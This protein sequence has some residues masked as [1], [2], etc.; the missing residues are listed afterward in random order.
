MTIA[1]LSGCGSK[2]VTTLAPSEKYEN[3]IVRRPG[4]SPE[5]SKVY[6]VL[7]HKKC[8]IIHAEWLGRHGY[9]WPDDVRTISAS[10]LEQIPIGEPI[11]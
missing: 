9:K 11:N 5:D 8:W 3:Q 10:E 2:P 4:D 1:A 7:D 6:V